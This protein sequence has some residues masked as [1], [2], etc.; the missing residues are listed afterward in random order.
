[1]ENDKG[2][3]LEVE[4]AEACKPKYQVENQKWE[5]RKR[6]KKDPIQDDLSEAQV[7]PTKTPQRINTQN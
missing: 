6:V 2:D 3:M 1:M 7:K 4:S 5:L